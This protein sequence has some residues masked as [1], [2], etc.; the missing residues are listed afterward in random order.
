MEPGSL[1]A[2]S[3]LVGSVVGLSASVATSWMSP[4]TRARGQLID[5]ELR[6]RE[7]LYAEFI[8]ECSKL[9]IDALDHS[10]DNPE[11]VLRVYALENRIKL[12]ASPPVVAAAAQAIQWIGEQ[13]TKT[14]LAPGELKQLVLTAFREPDNRSD[15]LKPFSE[16]CRRELASLHGAL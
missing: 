9:A 15:P 14:N 1:S 11:K 4:R 16:A 13:Y 3:A 7:E 12:C 2:V 10:L 6:K 8:S 5:A